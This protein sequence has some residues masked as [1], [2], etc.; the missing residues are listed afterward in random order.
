MLLGGMLGQITYHGK[1]GT[2]LP[3]LEIAR[4]VHIGKQTSFGLGQI[5]YA[6]RP[7]A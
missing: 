2:Y 6:W 1:I 7:D 3:L 4:Q 5:D